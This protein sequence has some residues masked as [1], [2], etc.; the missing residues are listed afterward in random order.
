MALRVEFEY[1]RLERSGDW[2]ELCRECEYCEFDKLC[3]RSCSSG[4]WNDCD[5]EAGC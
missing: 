5:D 4:C 2:F 1:C 3:G